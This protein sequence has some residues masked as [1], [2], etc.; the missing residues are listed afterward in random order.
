L[1]GPSA[2]ARVGG[3]ILAGAGK[4]RIKKYLPKKTEKRLPRHLKRRKRKL[5]IVIDHEAKQRNVLKRKIRE[6]ISTSCTLS[7]A[8]GTKGVTR[9]PAL[10]KGNPPRGAK[11]KALAA[12][13]GT[14]SAEKRG[15][16]RRLANGLQTGPDPAYSLRCGVLSVKEGEIRNGSESHERRGGK[17]SASEGGKCKEIIRH[18]T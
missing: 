1:R 15:S 14:T 18:P 13:T 5:V 17:K 12:P 9:E 6:Q 8:T 16:R 7:S 3:E 4:E 11:G 10:G 2:S